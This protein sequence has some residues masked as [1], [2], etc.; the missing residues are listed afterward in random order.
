MEEDVD[1]KYA[2]EIGG[3]AGAYLGAKVGEVWVLGGI[4]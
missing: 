2:L 4:V 3:D 1:V